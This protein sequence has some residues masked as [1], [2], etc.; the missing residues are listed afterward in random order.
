[1]CCWIWFTSI[2]LRIFRI[3][4]H[5]RFWS[6]VF[7]FVKYSSD[8]GIR[9]ILASWNE[10][11]IILSSYIFW[12]HIFQ[13]MKRKQLRILY[14][15]KLPCRNEGETKTFPHDGKRREFISSRLFWNYVI[16]FINRKESIFKERNGGAPRKK[17]RTT[18]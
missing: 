8:F 17:E 16:F 7:F 12:E 5:T 1:M 6:V 3:Y 4:K 10:F 18:A 15:A 13:L 2:L 11:G 14:P 9:V